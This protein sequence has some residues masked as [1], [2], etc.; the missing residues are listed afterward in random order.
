M[1]CNGYLSLIDAIRMKLFFNSFSLQKDKTY[2]L[3]IL[4]ESF[5]IRFRIYILYR[6]HI[7]RAFLF[8]ISLH[9]L[10]KKIFT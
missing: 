1:M 5:N 10:S 6:I 4:H 7:F 8:K 9:F 2:D 3:F